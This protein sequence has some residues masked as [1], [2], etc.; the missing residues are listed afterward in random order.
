MW[1]S[2][3][4]GTVFCKLLI[5][6]KAKFELLRQI[7]AYMPLT[8]NI[9]SRKS[10]YVFSPIFQKFHFPVKKNIVSKKINL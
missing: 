9:S 10:I 7:Y 5:F 1:K 3:E 2:P 6:T 8:F 4:N